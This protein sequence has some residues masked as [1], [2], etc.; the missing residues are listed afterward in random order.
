MDKARRNTATGIGSH[1]V[2]IPGKAADSQAV[3]ASNQ[4]AIAGLI[5]R[6]RVGASKGPFDAGGR[7]LVK[8]VSENLP[9]LTSFQFASGRECFFELTDGSGILRNDQ[10]VNFLSG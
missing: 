8:F 7:I 10:G 4:S 6:V 9:M 3:L 1:T 2:N 5:G